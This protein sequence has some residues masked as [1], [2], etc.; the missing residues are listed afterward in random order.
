MQVGRAAWPIPSLEM[1]LE[2]PTVS[3]PPHLSSPLLETRG[4]GLGNAARRRILQSQV[5]LSAGQAKSPVSEEERCEGDG[6]ERRD[7][8][9]IAC[10]S[11]SHPYAS[12]RPRGLPTHAGRDREMQ[13]PQEVSMCGWTCWSMECAFVSVRARV[14]V[15]GRLPPSTPAATRLLC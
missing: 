3:K 5:G 7:E 2:D 12:L 11:S 4:V 9:S 6:K 15:K 1:R 14:Q 13:K 8:G 10:W